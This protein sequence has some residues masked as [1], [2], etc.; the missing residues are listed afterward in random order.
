[1]RSPP[2]SLTRN[3]LYLVNF[4]EWNP[5]NPDYVEKGE[6]IKIG[7]MEMYVVG[8]GPNAIIWNYGRKNVGNLV[9]NPALLRCI[10]L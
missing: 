8:E 2:R 7:D 5:E 3:P 4:R 1:M 9:Q 6:I 10:W